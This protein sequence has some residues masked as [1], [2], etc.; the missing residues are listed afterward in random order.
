MK[1]IIIIGLLIAVAVV[2][3]QLNDFELF[4]INQTSMNACMVDVDCD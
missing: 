1:Q 2:V 4:L 3:E